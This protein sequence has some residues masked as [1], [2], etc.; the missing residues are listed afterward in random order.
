LRGLRSRLTLR[1]GDDVFSGGRQPGGRKRALIA[2]EIS[3]P[4]RSML[5][6]IGPMISEIGGFSVNRVSHS[7][8]E[9]VIIFVDGPP[10]R[11]SCEYLSTSV[12]L[13]RA[14]LASPAGPT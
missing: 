13:L 14:L 2:T 8:I 1:S 11:A 5:M 4:S 10:D 9:G 12:R 7:E 3:A 6:S